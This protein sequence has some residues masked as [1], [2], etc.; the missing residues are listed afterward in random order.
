MTFIMHYQNIK[1]KPVVFQFYS[2]A[3]DFREKSFVKRLV[4]VSSKCKHVVP[5]EGL[6]SEVM[7]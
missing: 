1:L 6:L 7:P 4:F 5:C 2:L 3:E